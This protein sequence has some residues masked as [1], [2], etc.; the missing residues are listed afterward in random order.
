MCFHCLNLRSVSEVNAA[1][2][3]R[4][5]LCRIAEIS[6]IYK[7][8]KLR[9]G[10]PSRLVGIMDVTFLPNHVTDVVLLMFTA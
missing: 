3:F 2:I 9:T 5:E 6:C 1:S 8:E 4:V 10:A 7:E